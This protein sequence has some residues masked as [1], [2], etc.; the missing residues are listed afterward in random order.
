MLFTFLPSPLQP[1]LLLRAKPD[2]IW[3]DVD[4]QTNCAYGNT[5]PNRI[6]HQFVSLSRSS[7]HVPPLFYSKIHTLARTNTSGTWMQRVCN[8]DAN[9]FTTGFRKW[10]STTVEQ[11]FFQNSIVHLCT[12]CIK[13]WTLEMSS[14]DLKWRLWKNWKEIYIETMITL[15]LTDG[16]YDF[17]L[18]QYIIYI[19]FLK[20]PQ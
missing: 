20:I 5:H 9:W 2:T 11:I 1:L 15:I 17:L 13:S 8:I 3:P 12:I 19:G 10:K 4:Q 14:V 7:F 6:S 16:A 18:L